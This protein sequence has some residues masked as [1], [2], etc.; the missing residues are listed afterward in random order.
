VALVVALRVDHVRQRLRLASQRFVPSG[1]GCAA[2]ERPPRKPR[3]AHR[4]DHV[5]PGHTDEHLAGCTRFCGVRESGDRLGRRWFLS[6]LKNH[7]RPYAQGV[8]LEEPQRVAC[9]WIQR[10]SS[11]LLFIQQSLAR[12]PD[13]G[14][15]QGAVSFHRQELRADCD[16]AQHT[17]GAGP[18][19]YQRI[20]SRTRE[21]LF[22]A[23]VQSLDGDG[24]TRSGVPDSP[25]V[26]S[27][28]RLFD[29]GRQ[30]L[31]HRGVACAAKSVVGQDGSLKRVTRCQAGPGPLNSP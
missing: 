24:A 3:L 14:R 19:R 8:V 4:V 16:R 31:W 13:S 5:P 9:C 2:E 17:I 6:R 29:S 22:P 18:L 20:L 10:R 23:L 21:L 30:E 15:I 12:R 27:D 25:V 26:F 7:Q 28:G 1:R 11:R